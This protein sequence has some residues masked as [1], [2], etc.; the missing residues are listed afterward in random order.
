MDDK[1][2]IYYMMLHK[3]LHGLIHIKIKKNIESVINKIPK[4]ETLKIKKNY[5]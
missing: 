3:K 2:I 4:N 5:L 1:I